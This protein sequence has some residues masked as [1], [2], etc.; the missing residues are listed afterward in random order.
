MTSAIL[1]LKSSDGGVKHMTTMLIFITEPFEIITRNTGPSA[2]RQ[3]RAKTN[4]SKQPQ[5]IDTIWDILK[6][7][8]E[9]SVRQFKLVTWMFLSK[10]Y[11]K[12]LKKNWNLGHGSPIMCRNYSMMTMRGDWFMPIAWTHGWSVWNWVSKWEQSYNFPVFSYVFD[13]T[14]DGVLKCH[15]ILYGQHDKIPW[16]HLDIRK[17]QI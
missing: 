16:S 13:F 15:T 10:R 3:K 8:P 14:F 17:K 2:N 6:V 4:K 12:L 1:W 11:L 9:K 5:N 7:S